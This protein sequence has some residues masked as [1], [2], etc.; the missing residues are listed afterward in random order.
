MVAIPLSII[1]A[2][3]FMYAL[4][5]SLNMMSLIALSL[6]VGILV[7]DSIVVV[8]NMVHYL[9]MGKSK[10]RAAL[11]GSKANHVYLYGHYPC[12]CGVFLPLAIAGGMIGNILKEFA[13]RLL[14]PCFAA[15]WFVHR[16]AAVDVAFWKTIG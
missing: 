9:E 11:E 4:G 7:D 12:Y 6:V 5:F 13:I 2:F 1:P 3:I 8:E 15:F 10:W 14:S 16:N